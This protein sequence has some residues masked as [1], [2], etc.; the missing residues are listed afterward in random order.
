MTVE[1]PTGWCV[2]FDDAIKIGALSVEPASG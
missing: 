1:L 2:E